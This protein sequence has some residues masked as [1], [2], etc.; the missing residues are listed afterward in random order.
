MQFNIEYNAQQ[1]RIRQAARAR[2]ALQQQIA[3]GIRNQ[4]NITANFTTKILAAVKRTEPQKNPDGGIIL[5]AIFLRLSSIIKTLRSNPEAI[6]SY[7]LLTTLALDVIKEGCYLQRFSTG[8]NQQDKEL[9]AAKKDAYRCLRLLLDP[10]VIQST[11][12]TNGNNSLSFLHQ[13]LTERKASKK[14]LTIYGSIQR[15]TPSCSLSY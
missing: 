3:N 6:N 14:K 11:R 10:M 9:A 1:A 13:L 15:K 7:K 8:K 12:N 2:Q 4:T 5:Q